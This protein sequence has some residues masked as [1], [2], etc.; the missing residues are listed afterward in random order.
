MLRSV[1]LRR[2]LDEMREAVRSPRQ[3]DTLPPW[4][5]GARNHRRIVRPQTLPRLRSTKGKCHRT[6][7][8]AETLAEI[9]RRP[10]AEADRSRSR[11]TS[12]IKSNPASNRRPHQLAEFC[13]CNRRQAAAKRRA[14]SAIVWPMRANPSFAS[15][16]R[17]ISL[18]YVGSSAAHG[19]DRSHLQVTVRIGSRQV[20]GGAPGQE[21]GK[22][23]ELPGGGEHTRAGSPSTIATWA[24]PSRRDAAADIAQHR[25]AR[26]LIRSA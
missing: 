25:V 15:E 4:A 10:A 22:I 11:N 6:G 1:S 3:L 7:R 16:P 17:P 13:R 24:S 20:A 8:S 9:G 23:E 12:R 19:R 18:K 2:Q 14:G 21:V 5:N 26:A